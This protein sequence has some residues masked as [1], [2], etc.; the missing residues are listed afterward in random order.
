MNEAKECSA[1][2][3]PRPIEIPFAGGMVRGHFWP[4]GSDWAVLLHEPG[5]DLDAWD[6][7]P[8]ALAADGYAV[9]AVDL[10]GHGLSD[11]PWAPGRAVE[12]VHA[13]AVW[14]NG[15][16]A[17]KVFVIAAREM[18]TAAAIARNVDALVAFSPSPF[19]IDGPE[20]TPPTLAL[21]G[22]SDDGAAERANRFF[23]Q[24]RGWAVSSSFG[25][26]AQGSAI[27]RSDWGQ[28][29]LEQTLGFLRDYRSN[30]RG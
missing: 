3:E 22:G 29:A 30:G 5:S 15:E 9:L 17:S 2:V 4:G 8:V 26:E 21:V 25:T 27:F 7:V 10:P 23:R 6:G 19:P 14:A 13:L 16:G 12:L 11:D 24:T 18:A 20:T 1:S 28:H